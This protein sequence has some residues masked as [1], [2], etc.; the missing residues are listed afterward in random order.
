MILKGGQISV[1]LKA[2][3]VDGH[4]ILKLECPTVVHAQISC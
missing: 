1:K 2:V 4:S 3:T